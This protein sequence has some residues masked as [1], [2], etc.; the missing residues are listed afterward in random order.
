[1]VFV[2]IIVTPNVY[3]VLEGSLLCIKE[4]SGVNRLIEGVFG[5]DPRSE[6]H[7]LISRIGRKGKE[8]NA[9]F[10]YTTVTDFA[11]VGSN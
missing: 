3:G 4:I 1:M 6:P 5:N 7:T 2:Y 9:I 11:P 10:Q 8:T